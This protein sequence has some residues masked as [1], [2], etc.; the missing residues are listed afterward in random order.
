MGK[1]AELPGGGGGG[2]EGGGG[3][4]WRVGRRLRLGRAIAQ[5][6]GQRAQ[7]ARAAARARPVQLGAAVVEEVAARHH[8]ARAAHE[9]HHPRARRGAHVLEPRVDV[10]VVDLH[11]EVAQG[12]PRVPRV[13]QLAVRVLDQ[14]PARSRA[15]GGGEHLAH[16]RPGGAE[17]GDEGV[18]AAA[19]GTRARGGEG[20]WSGPGLVVRDEHPVVSGR[21]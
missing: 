20:S 12:L 6:L 11:E 21:V 19:R 1:V 7:V 4:R 2:G 5:P 10:L 13:R 17:G 9:V 15:E 3:W 8:A 14:G 16:R 18:R